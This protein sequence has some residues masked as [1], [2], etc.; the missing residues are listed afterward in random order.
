[1]TITAAVDAGACRELTKRA[2]GAEDTA[3]ESDLFT[4]D[5]GFGAEDSRASPQEKFEFRAERRRKRRL[6]CAD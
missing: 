6:Q 3:Q 1:M 4:R 5:F 2:G